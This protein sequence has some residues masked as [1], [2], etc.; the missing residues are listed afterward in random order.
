MIMLV[1]AYFYQRQSQQGENNEIGK[2]EIARLFLIVL[3]F[4][5][6]LGLNGLTQIKKMGDFTKDVTTNW[7]FGIETI[8]QVNL[9]IEQFLSNYYQ[10]LNQ[11]IPSK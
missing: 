9:N 1:S 7:M 3:V 10:T 4:V 5:V 8:N 11:K 6:V 2:N